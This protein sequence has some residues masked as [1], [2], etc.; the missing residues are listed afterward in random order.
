MDL[1]VDAGPHGKAVNHV[2]SLLRGKALRPQERA[3]IPPHLARVCDSYVRK[4]YAENLGETT[5]E[6]PA[7]LQHLESY[8]RVESALQLYRARAMDAESFRKL[9]RGR[10][11]PSYLQS[12]YRGIL[13]YTTGEI[14]RGYREF[15]LAKI[16]CE[17]LVKIYERYFE[18][19]I[20]GVLSATPLE[21][22]NACLAAY[23]PAAVDRAFPI[24]LLSAP[25]KKRAHVLGCDAPYWVKYAP[26][27]HAW[28]HE[29]TKTNELWVVCVDFSEAALQK[30]QQDFPTVKFARSQT[31]FSN[32]G[33]Y[34]T[35]ARFLLAER[36]SRL[37]DLEIVCSDIDMIMDLN[38]YD[39]YVDACS[40]GLSAV[41]RRGFVPWRSSSADFSVWKGERSRTALKFFVSY[42][43]RVF[44]P[45][46]PPGNRQWWIDQFPL[47]MIA[48]ASNLGLARVEEDLRCFNVIERRRRPLRSPVDERMSK[49]RFVELYGAAANNAQ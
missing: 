38:R 45:A 35:M 3:L 30:A 5:E 8:V 32:R 13:R 27:L 40:D 43:T 25:E 48:D 33:P 37:A 18:G 4:A 21:E 49:E 10:Q 20:R 46:I 11:T 24:E 1:N 6:G 22:M 42:F 31:K 16:H 14:E 19:S 23:D 44:Q 12:Y 29:F 39:D 17:N 36:L 34:S 2:F 7:V 41:F 47:S 28:A 26:L 9:A 15:A